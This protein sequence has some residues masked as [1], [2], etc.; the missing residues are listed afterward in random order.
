MKDI[1][2]AAIARVLAAARAQ[3][4]HP[5]IVAMV[6]AAACGITLAEAFWPAEPPHSVMQS[7]GAVCGAAM[8]KRHSE[9][10]AAGMHVGRA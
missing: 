3:G 2:E 7:V 6:L 9:L 10:R 1:S 4:E 8:M 5:A